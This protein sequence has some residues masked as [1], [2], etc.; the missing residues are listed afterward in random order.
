[1]RWKHNQFW[2]EGIVA[3]VFK[4]LKNIVYSSN[5]HKFFQNNIGS[6]LDFPRLSNTQ[7]HFCWV[8]Q[9]FQVPMDASC[10]FHLAAEPSINPCNLVPSQ[11]HVEDRI[12]GN[13]LFILHNIHQNSSQQ[14]LWMIL[15]EIIL[16]NRDLLLL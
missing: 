4:L 13:Y 9:Q 16:R 8:L 5:V 12:N 7:V 11:C 6:N 2:K 10:V 14:S 15:G 3:I 1:M